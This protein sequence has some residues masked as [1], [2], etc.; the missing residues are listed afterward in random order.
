MSSVASEC[1]ERQ[2]VSTMSSVA[3]ERQERQS[4][5]RV[6]ASERPAVA[7]PVLA[8]RDVLALQDPERLLEGLDLLLARFHALL[9]AEP[10]VE[11]VGFQLVVV[12]QGLVQ[13]LLCEGELLLSCA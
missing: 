5:R 7:A 13:L 10:C 11:A 9:V 6:R 8:S 1:Q 12:A 2:G 3:S 4:V